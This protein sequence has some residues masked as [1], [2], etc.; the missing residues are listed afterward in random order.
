VI[1]NRYALLALILS[2]S[3]RRKTSA[4]SVRKGVKGV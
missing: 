4:N 1:Q 3:I 2:T